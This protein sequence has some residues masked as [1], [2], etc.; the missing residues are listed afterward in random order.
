M[1]DAPR[2]T[3]EAT[4]IVGHV[5]WAFQSGT[6]DSWVFGATEGVFPQPTI[7]PG[8]PTNSWVD[9]GS[10]A[11]VL[12]AFGTGSHITKGTGYYRLYKCTN[13]ATGNPTLAYNE[14]ISGGRTGYNVFTDN[15][16]TKAIAIL[17]AYG[18]T[19]LADGA[20]SPSVGL[21]SLPDT[22]F[23]NLPRFDSA[24]TFLLTVPVLLQDPLNHAWIRTQPAHPQRPLRVAIYDRNNAFVKELDTTSFLVAGT[25]KYVGTV[26]VPPGTIAKSSVYSVKTRLDFT[27]FRYAPGFD[28]EG[29]TAVTADTPLTI[30]DVNEDNHV[31]TI[32]YNLIGQCFSDIAPPK[33]PCNAALARATDLDDDSHVNG[34]D[35][36]LYLRVVQNQG[37]A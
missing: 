25:D 31:N 2:G 21:N 3:G 32:D 14:A 27:L 26:G 18:L 34:T 37:G 8:K 12:Q 9:T 20:V 15:C 6:G 17:R 4:Q 7:D 29:V 35:V 11:K 1:F 28:Q 16:L 5:G 13:V 19:G 10:W 33:G 30:G 22:Y 36:N 24:P 23:A